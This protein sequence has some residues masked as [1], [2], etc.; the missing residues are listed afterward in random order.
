MAVPFNIPEDQSEVEV[1]LIQ[2]QTILN[3]LQ[4][5]VRQNHQLAQQPTASIP[6]GSRVRYSPD[7][8]VR[9]REVLQS[10]ERIT[11]VPQNVLPDL[12][13]NLSWLADSSNEAS[14]SSSPL[15]AMSA[16][17]RRR[18]TAS[19]SSNPDETKISVTAIVTTDFCAQ[20]WNEKNCVDSGTSNVIPADGLFSKLIPGPVSSCS[21]MTAM[22]CF[23]GWHIFRAR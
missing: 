5:T 17:S 4:A 9:S 6:S 12:L 10:V 23:V 3:K 1:L 2:L 7:D 19:E 22:I 13:S 11:P 14:S 15:T 21:L 20:D 8:R 18:R 16:R